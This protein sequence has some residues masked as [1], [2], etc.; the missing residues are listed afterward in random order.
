MI[1]FLIFWNLEQYD[2]ALKYS[3]SCRRLVRKLLDQQGFG[4][5]GQTDPD[6]NNAASFTLTEVP[7]TQDSQ[8]TLSGKPKFSTQNML[9]LL[10]V[11]EL[12]CTQASFQ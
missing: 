9:N 1:T 12:A 2:Q 8:S 3:Q 10:A 5:G 11:V 7:E 6:N 4:E